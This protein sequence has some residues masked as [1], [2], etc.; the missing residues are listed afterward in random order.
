MKRPA[1]AMGAAPTSPKTEPEEV[2]SDA[3]V[4]APEHS[5]ELPK[6]EPTVLK[7]PAKA[8]PAPKP[9]PKSKDAPTKKPA[10][11]SDGPPKPSKTKSSIM[12]QAKAWKQ[13]LASKDDEATG[14]E[15]PEE[16]EEGGLNVSDEES[17]GE[18]RDKGKGQKWKKMCDQNAIPSHILEMFH[19]ESKKQKDPRKWKTQII[20]KL[21]KKNP[22]TK[23]YDMVADQ[24]WFNNFREASTTDFGVDQ[25]KGEPKSVFLHS[26]FHG[27]E[28]G[29]RQAIAMGDV[30]EWEADG[31]I[32]CS[33]RSTKAGTKKKNEEKQ[34]VGG[35]QVAISTEQHKALTG[36]FKS[37]RWTFSGSQTER[38]SSLPSSSAYPVKKQKAIE[39]CGLNPEMK[40][41]LTEAKEANER[42][43][44]SALKLLT[45]CPDQQ[46][47]TLKG[48]IVE[49]KDTLQNAEHI[50]LFE[51]NHKPV[52]T[53]RKTLH[54]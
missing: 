47:T 7:K 48:I 31:T 50:L 4:V 38:P 36:A 25:T 30:Q 1:A 10:G 34:Q 35:G 33:Y 20:N 45:N 11:R 22:V 27:N 53:V 3:E 52:T 41:M 51:D 2:K 17:D 40:K 44:N 42:M 37:M 23:K 6:D 32:W 29:L 15:E 18:Y 5:E 8:K 12:D 46:K 24:P 21:F 19:K 14:E 49:I 39:N 9:K 43:L 28:E 16:E 54:S 26:K 13:G